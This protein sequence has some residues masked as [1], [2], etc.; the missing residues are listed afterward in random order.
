MTP[1]NDAAAVRVTG[2]DSLPLLGEGREAQTLAWS[3][4]RVLRLLK[5]PAHADRLGRERIALAAARA[6]GAPVPQ[7]YGALTVD[8]RPGM[9][10]ERIDGPNLLS[11]LADRPWLLP[12]IARTLGETQARLHAAVVHEGLPTVHEIIRRALTESRLIPA[13]FTKPALARLEQLPGGDTL[14]HWDFQPANVILG[15]RGP[16]VV[17]WSFAAR[18]HPA[19][20]VART[21]LILAIGEPPRDAG[22]VIRRLDVL[23]RRALS[24]LY[25]RAYA[26]ARPIETRLVNRWLPLVALPRLTA[27]VPEERGRLIALIDDAIRAG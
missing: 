17:D 25:L 7:D 6:A 9:V 24:A 19:A 4:N 12:R 22:V 1:T 18:G 15:A 27:N 20:D 16:R 26:K 3:E 14:C 2:A 23:G 10:L 5:D 21:R 11:L 13:R 8:E